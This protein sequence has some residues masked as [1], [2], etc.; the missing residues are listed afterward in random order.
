MRFVKGGKRLPPPW[1]SVKDAMVE[2]TRNQTLLELISTILVTMVDSSADYINQDD[3]DKV[4]TLIY[5]W[6]REAKEG[7][8]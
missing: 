6:A 8:A 2:P 1:H 7:V 4:L 5:Q 3:Y